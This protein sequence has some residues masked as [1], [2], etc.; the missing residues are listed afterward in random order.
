MRSIEDHNG[1]TWDVAVGKESYGA[2]VLLFFRRRDNDIRRLPIEVGSRL[3]AERLLRTMSDEA[4]ALKLETAL[5]WRDASS[6]S[7][8]GG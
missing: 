8:Q 6:S 5:P 2:M 1:V 4:L 3:E 7:R